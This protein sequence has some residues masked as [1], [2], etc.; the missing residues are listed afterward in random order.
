M[1]R[2]GHLSSLPQSPLGLCKQLR[3]L[4]TTVNMSILL[5]KIT[6]LLWVHVHT[7]QASNCG[8]F[9][10]GIDSWCTQQQHIGSSQ[11]ISLSTSCLRQCHIWHR[12]NGKVK[13]NC[14]EKRWERIDFMFRQCLGLHWDR[15]WGT[16]SRKSGW[17]CVSSSSCWQNRVR[18]LAWWWHLTLLFLD[19][20]GDPPK[21]GA[22]VHGIWRGWWYFLCKMD[23]QLLGPQ[24]DRWE[25]ERG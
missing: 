12:C 1:G 15:F 16:E 7:S 17:N 13:R 25:W 6:S 24:L 2:A 9:S 23:E 5:L 14:V 11:H 18:L 10:I 4:L 21:F 8:Q 22:S 19:W 3:Q 20:L